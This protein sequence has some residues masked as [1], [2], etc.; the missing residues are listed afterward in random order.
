MPVSLK[1][2]NSYELIS[3]TP[4]GKTMGTALKIELEPK[5]HCNDR[6]GTFDTFLPLNE[7]ICGGSLD[8]EGPEGARKTS[9]SQSP[10]YLAVD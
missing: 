5:A 6:P 2:S 10:Q 3:G 9:F 7:L 1:M 8:W 4:L